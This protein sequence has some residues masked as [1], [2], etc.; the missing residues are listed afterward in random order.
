M[1]VT[2]IPSVADP[3]AALDELGLS[4]PV[5]PDDP[6]YINWRSTQGGQIFISGQLPYRD[7]ILPVTGSVSDRADADPDLVDIDTAREMMQQA[8]LN[9]LAVAADATGGLDRVRVVQLLVFVLSAPG[10]GQ[11]SKVAD[12]GSEM[13]V[14]VLGEEGRHART[15]IGV[16]GLPRSSPVEVQMVCEVRA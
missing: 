4:L 14:Q 13:L 6:K 16:A 8:T 15:A 5:I 1:T 12:A 7:G 3:D 11:Q 2:P 9:A 10:F